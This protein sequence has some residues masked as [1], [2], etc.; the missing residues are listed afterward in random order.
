MKT[1]SKALKII[2][3]LFLAALLC[4]AFI[5][6]SQNADREDESGINGG[7]KDSAR[8]VSFIEQTN[9]PMTDKEL[10]KM[11]ASYTDYSARLFS[12]CVKSDGGENVFVSPLSAYFAL[13]MAANGAQGETLS[14]FG[15]LLGSDQILHLNE[16]NEI[17][18]KLLT[19]TKGNTLFSVANSMWVHDTGNKNFVKDLFLSNLLSYYNAEVNLR[20]FA[21]KSVPGEINDWVSGKTNG[22]IK[23]LISEIPDDTFSILINTIYMKAQWQHTFSHEA[24]TEMNFT[25]NTGSVVKTD[26]LCSDNYHGYTARSKGIDGVKLMYNDDRLAFLAVRATDGR[27]APELAASLDG[28]TIKMLA[29]AEKTTYINVQMPKFELEYKIPLNNILREMGLTDA[30]DPDKCDF[31]GMADRDDLYISEVLQKTKI[32]VDEKGTE[33]AAATSIMVGT[34][35]MPIDSPLSYVFDTPYVYIIIDTETSAP[36]FMGIMNNPAK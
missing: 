35:S 16:F 29:S 18:M 5:S 15:T 20:D 11:F 3:A 2:S 10:E 26:F 17:F 8:E 1:N 25:T 19:E 14:Q 31:S 6:C 23:D 12:L 7:K 9:V 32:I 22:L 33:A 21:K 30:F 28:E 13:S 24:T 4:V 27:S 34:T 36:I